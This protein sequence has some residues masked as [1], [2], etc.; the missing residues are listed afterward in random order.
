MGVNEL[1]RGGP[2]Q[3]ESHSAS[4]GSPEDYLVL[5]QQAQDTVESISRLGWWLSRRGEQGR[6]ING[7]Q[8]LSEAIGRANVNLDSGEPNLVRASLAE[9]ARSA[10]S[11]CPVGS[12]RI[13]AQAAWI[14]TIGPVTGLAL[15][16]VTED[17]VGRIT[18]EELE[19]ERADEG[20]IFGDE[21]AKFANRLGVENDPITR[22]EAVLSR[23]IE[24]VRQLPHSDPLYQRYQNISHW[25]F[26]G[27]S[28]EDLSLVES[29][30][31][32]KFIT[33]EGRGDHQYLPGDKIYTGH[34]GS[35]PASIII[36]IAQNGD[37]ICR[38][39]ANPKDT[40]ISPDRATL[41][42]PSDWEDF[43]SLA[44]GDMVEL[45]DGSRG[46]VVQRNVN[47]ED[48]YDYY[49][50]PGLIVEDAAGGQH[51]VPEFEIDH[52]AR[53]SFDSLPEEARARRA[54]RELRA[55]RSQLEKAVG[56]FPERALSDDEL[57]GVGRRLGL[58]LIVPEWV[59]LDRFAKEDQIT[60]LID[61]YFTESTED[62]FLIHYQDKP[63]LDSWGAIEAKDFDQRRTLFP[64]RRIA[65]KYKEAMA[66]RGSSDVA[67]ARLNA[68]FAIDAAHYLRSYSRDDTE[69]RNEAIIRKIMRELS[70]VYSF[71]SALG[72][73]EE[74]SWRQALR[75]DLGIELPTFDE[76]FRVEA[77]PVSTRRGNSS[78][79][80]VFRG[81]ASRASQAWS[82]FREQ[83]PEPDVEFTPAS[84]EQQL[85]SLADSN[86]SDS[87]IPVIRQAG[88]LSEIVFEGLNLDWPVQIILG[89]ALWYFN[90]LSHET[91][92]EGRAAFQQG[93]W[94]QWTF[95]PTE[96]GLGMQDFYKRF[97]G[98]LGQTYAGFSPEVRA[99]VGSLLGDFGDPQKVAGEIIKVGNAYLG[100]RESIRI[101]RLLE[102]QPIVALIGSEVSPADRITLA[103]AYL[104]FDGVARAGDKAGVV[105]FQRQ[106]SEQFQSGQ[107][108]LPPREFLTSLALP[109]AEA[110]ADLPDV[111][112]LRITSE[113]GS[114]GQE[115]A[116]VG[117]VAEIKRA[118]GEL[119]DLV[120]IIDAGLLMPRPI[121]P[122]SGDATLVAFVPQIK[123]AL[124]QRWSPEWGDISDADLVVQLREII[125]QNWQILSGGERSRLSTDQ[126]TK[127]RELLNPQLND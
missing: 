65:R 13:K 121:R 33:T 84:R 36:N 118:D 21:L 108:K 75:D 112:K 1:P 109:L 35:H 16:E 91:T 100:A 80:R 15:S 6:A 61:K 95:S 104:Y 4:S 8:F 125:N 79:G 67:R 115:I 64:I 120:S 105:A 85:E 56:Y 26:W 111:T 12:A 110:Y 52:A 119:A 86:I 7:L 2:I 87:G 3:V 59:N 96:R 82:G 66:R 19:S 90:G 47:Q 127:I 23:I 94:Q 20:Y 99:R 73:Q 76:Y 37:L 117:R 24:I 17:D 51:A 78:M 45:R 46:R 122:Q 5:V 22:R 38:S 113:L 53:V 126:L 88:R 70:H 39:S 114:V 83:T 10:F 28:G 40:T 101:N 58:D 48:Q 43:G 102:Q 31:G 107:E 98:E 92:P 55:V 93:F 77:G 32:T 44:I 25:Q 54:N 106:F 116:K 11:L 18:L 63:F 62:L 27:L 42:P 14:D 124:T 89:R 50:D 97:A 60:N 30:L 123:Q 68:F 34:S 71:S 49:L 74:A 57:E 72:V 9:Q 69:T 41:R 103:K 29:H 81:L